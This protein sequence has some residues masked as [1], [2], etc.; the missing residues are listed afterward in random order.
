M[1]TRKTTVRAIC[2]HWCG[3]THPSKASCELCAICWRC[4]G[5][6]P[7]RC[8][9]V[10]DSLGGPDIPS[11]YVLLCNRCHLDAPD[12]RDPHEMLR[13]IS[14]SDLPWISDMKMV[15]GH[16]ER[17]DGL[18]YEKLPALLD[19]FN[20]RLEDIAWHRGF[21]Q[22]TKDWAVRTAIAD[23]LAVP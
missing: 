12:V 19:C 7:E 5:S 3:T 8:H 15:L 16:L 2:E 4:Y 6:R 11:N 18:T 22:A 13:W 23:F 20:A 21:S 14:E 9:I 1:S 17:I 10:P